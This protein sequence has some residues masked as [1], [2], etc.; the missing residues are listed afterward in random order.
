[1]V[2]LFLM[3]T[4]GLML[5][6]VLILVTV[7]VALLSFAHGLDPDNFITP[8]VTTLGDLLGIAFLVLVLGALL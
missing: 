5:A 6:G 3:L 7:A 8:V 1:E 2:L 4:T